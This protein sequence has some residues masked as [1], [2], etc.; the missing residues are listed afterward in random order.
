MSL[1]VRN[2]AN[3]AGCGG[4][5]ERHVQSMSYECVIR[6]R[7]LHGSSTRRRQLVTTIFTSFMGIDTRTRAHEHHDHGI[8]Q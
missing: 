3:G 8:V 2:C 7:Y 4:C 1:G 5:R 6:Y